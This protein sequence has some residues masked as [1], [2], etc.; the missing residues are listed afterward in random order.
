LRVKLAL[1][2]LSVLGYGLV[3]QFAEAVDNLQGVP[4][5]QFWF[6]HLVGAIFGGLVMGPYAVSRQLGLRVVAL[7]IAS[8]LIYYFAVWFVT[9]GPLDLGTV[10]TFVLTGAAAALLVGLA[11]VVIAPARASA[12]LIPATLAAGALGG[13]AFKLRVTSD[14]I[15]LLGHAVWQLLVCL[16]LHLSFRN[17]S[18]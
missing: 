9:N 18:R 5:P 14:T 8:A 13:A 11:V 17:A 3:F 1:A 15:M 6:Y 7:C 2:A 4:D 10:A 12:L 16:A